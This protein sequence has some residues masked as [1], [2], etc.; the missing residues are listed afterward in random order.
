MNHPFHSSNKDVAQRWSQWQ[1]DAPQH[2]DD[3][4]P[5]GQPERRKAGKHRRTVS[6]KDF[7]PSAKP[8][9]LGDKLRDK[10]VTESIAQVARWLA[11]ET[12]HGALW[13]AGLPRHAQ[14][15]LAAA[16]V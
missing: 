7:D 3:K 1:P 15:T 8:F 2:D 6:L 13:Q 10:A 9:S 16:A 12:L 4:R 5:D 11:G 14:P